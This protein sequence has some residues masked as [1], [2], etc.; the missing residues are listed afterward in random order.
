LGGRVGTWHLRAQVYVFEEQC[1][2]NLAGKVPFICC[3]RIFIEGKPPPFIYLHQKNSTGPLHKK[4]VL[5]ANRKTT[6]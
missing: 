2:R 6:T 1:L 4:I 3:G 5:G